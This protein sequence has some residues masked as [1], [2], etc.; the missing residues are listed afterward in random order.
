MGEKLGSRLIW[1]SDSKTCSGSRATHTSPKAQKTA[2]EILAPHM[3]VVIKLEICELEVGSHKFAV[4]W[5]DE[6]RT[7]GA[8]F[9]KQRC[10]RKDLLGLLRPN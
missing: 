4:I 8:N 10:R 7:R 6:Q 3:V 9:K 5:T 1:P 2:R